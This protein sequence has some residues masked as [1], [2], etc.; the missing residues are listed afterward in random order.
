[1][2]TSEYHQRLPSPNDANRH[3]ADMRV[4]LEAVHAG[5]LPPIS[6]VALPDGLDRS[7]LKTQ[8]FS[9][10]TRN[11]LSANEL[12]EGTNRILVDELLRLRN[13]GTTSLRDLLIVVENFLKECS[14]DNASHQS[15]IDITS[16]PPTADHQRPHPI[17]PVRPSPSEALRHLANMQLALASVHAGV[18]PPSSCVV[19]PSGLDRSLLKTQPFSVRTHNCLTSGRLFTGSDQL[20]VQDLTS[21][22]NFGR[23][24]LQDLLLVVEGYL[25]ECIRDSDQH[26]SSISPA[27]SSSQDTAQED[28]VR[29]PLNKLLSAASEFYGATSIIDLLAPDVARLASSIGVYETLQAASIESVTAEHTPLSTKVATKAQHLYET[30]PPTHRTVLDR[31][32]LADP[33]DTLAKVAQAM[34]VSRERVRQLHAKL[35]RQCRMTFGPELR[36]ISSIIKP[37]LGSIAREHSVNSRIDSLIPEDGTPGASLARREVKRS[38][39]YTRTMN[40]VC[41]QESA[42]AIVDQLQRSARYFV[43]DGIIDQAGLRAVLPDRGWER[44]W[45]LLLRCCGFY[46]IFGVLA[47]RDSDKA[48][49]KAALLSIGSPASRDEIA[50]LCG[51]S[52][53]TVGSYL[54]SFPSVVR[55]DLSRWGLS[56]WIDDEYKGIE[57]EII[58]RIEEGGGVTT[59]SRLFKE[60]PTK[61][62]VSRSSVNTY[63]QGP[64]FVVHDDG[65]VT[66][67]DT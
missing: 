42:C 56:E 24:S 34:G 44:N 27:P 22:R 8:P 4:A 67:A 36:T 29:E 61:F 62:G 55:A 28:P 1:M 65:H 20:L 33:P 6:C 2:S 49:T 30:V 5:D 39:G 46:E 12:F 59:A 7:L 32:F 47:L 17:S 23:T 45:G 31:R 60:L 48:R 25:K 26:V 15:V 40:G 58:Q 38:L 9:V 43:E 51:L 10:R 63:L 35:T 57:A 53:A 19:L 11:C 50:N 21:L 66:L 52:P 54:S 3:L 37:Q 18:S 64:K 14:I 41:L 16:N 13:F